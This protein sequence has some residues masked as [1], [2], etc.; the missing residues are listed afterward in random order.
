MNADLNYFFFGIL[1]FSNILIF[2][3]W[4]MKSLK[5]VNKFR[6]LLPYMLLFSTLMAIDVSYIVIFSL[7]TVWC[8]YHFYTI[9]HNWGSSWLLTLI[10]V[11]LIST[12][13]F[14]SVDVNRY[15]KLG[16]STVTTFVEEFIIYILLVVCISL[17]DK[18]Y[19]VLSY[20]FVLKKGQYRL[21][22]V[23]TLL[24]LNIIFMQI[25]LI[26][27]KHYFY[28]SFQLLVCLILLLIC[29]VY[30]VYIEYRL[31]KLSLE[32]QLLAQK[33]NYYKE[34]DGF[35]HDFKALLFSL[36]ATVEEKNIPATKAILDSVSHYSFKIIDNYQLLN[37]DNKAIRSIIKEL[38]G[39]AK[40]RGIELKLE[41]PEQ[42]VFDRININTFDLIRLL[43]IILNNAIEAS[44]EEKSEVNLSIINVNDKHIRIVCKNKMKEKSNHDFKRWFKRN[45]TTKAGHKGLGL[46]NFEKITSQYKDLF[47]KFVLDGKN[48]EFI[49]T[50]DLFD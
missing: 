42:V 36:Y 6:M 12:S 16:L 46:V 35:R 40:S 11:F 49:V 8:I 21:L 43:S 32:A 33:E 44:E 10:A 25:Y 5:M 48:Q 30:T 37:I 7:S 45:Q 47:Y 31:N 39:E 29:I 15:L 26:G 20:L 3:F 4:L 41:V 24:V 28:V 38:Q 2:H 23:Y 22:A 17:I 1:I 34:L 14:L 50:M 13:L 18:R 27:R 19:H 9:F